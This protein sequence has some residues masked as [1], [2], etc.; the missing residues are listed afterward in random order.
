[1]MCIFGF[2]GVR[3]VQWNGSILTGP[4]SSVSMVLTRVDVSL[5]SAGAS[6]MRELDL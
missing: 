1:M 6:Q 5:M 3:S 4:R 2:N